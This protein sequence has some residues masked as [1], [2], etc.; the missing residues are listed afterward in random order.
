M[1]EA[2]QEEAEVISDE[3]KET[4]NTEKYLIFSI[5]GKQYSFPSK[6]I[7]EIALFDHV[8]PL[9]LVPSY[10]LGVVNRYSVP[11][12]LFDIGLL[13]NKTP[14]PQNKVLIFKDEID[15]IA[16]LIDDVT[17]IADIHP[18]DIF[19]HE[20]SIDQSELTDAVAVSFSWNGNDVFVLDIHR[21]LERV[22]REMA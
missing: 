4:V 8:Y 2:E 1:A 6:Y 5:L 3:Q 12:A 18:E 20:R 19:A 9:P 11:Y 10:V 16:V 14:C 7:G 13:F 15:R 17:G 22:S 21:I